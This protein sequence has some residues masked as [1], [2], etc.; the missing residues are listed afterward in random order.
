LA[1]VDTLT[2]SIPPAGL[3]FQFHRLRDFDVG[4]DALIEVVGTDTDPQASPGKLLGA[5][6]KAGPHYF[7]YDDGD[8]WT[9]YV[10]KSIVDYWLS[11][12]VPVVLI[13]VDLSTGACYWTRADV[14]TH[15]Q[16]ERGFRVR[17]PKTQRYD[18]SARDAIRMLAED[19]PPR[20][21]ELIDRSRVSAELAEINTAQQAAQTAADHVAVAERYLGLAGRL[22]QRGRYRE[23]AQR[24][25]SAVKAFRRAGELQRAAQE[26][27][28]LLRFLVDDLRNG[29]L[30]TLL[31]FDAVTPDRILPGGVEEPPR[32]WNG[33]PTDVL[34]ALDVAM[35]EAYDLGGRPGPAAD[36]AD[37][38]QRGDLAPPP[39]DPALPARLRAVAAVGDEEHAAAARAYDEAAETAREPTKILEYRVRAALHGGLVGDLRGA[40]TRLEGLQA[41]SASTSIET[42]R[43]RAYGWLLVLSARSADGA[44]AF[45]AASQ[46]HVAS[47]EALAAERAIANAFWA[48]QHS[49]QRVHELFA[50]G[51]LVGE[52]RGP[53]EAEARDREVVT[54]RELLAETDRHLARA[55][56]HQAYT[57]ARRALRLAYEDVDAAGVEQVRSRL[58][59]IWR[60]AS[61]F[62]PDP[63]TL[64]EALRLTVRTRAHL[65]DDAADLQLPPFYERLRQRADSALRER[66]VGA[67][68]GDLVGT[69]EHEGALRV[70][71][72]LSDLV[73]DE[74]L[75][76]AAVPL[77]VAGLD[78]GWGTKGSEAALRLTSEIG[79][80]LSSAGAA[81][82]RE[83]L[84]ALIPSTPPTRLDVVYLALAN[85]LGK[86]DV[87][88]DGGAALAA[89]FQAAIE[90]PQAG[91]YLPALYAAMGV[92]A[93]RATSDVRAVLVNTLRE[94]GRKSRDAALD[95]L[96]R[97]EIDFQ[98]E[99]AE[100]YLARM[101]DGL[102]NRLAEVGTNRRSG[103]WPPLLHLVRWAAPRVRAEA[104]DECLVAA[105]D[106]VDEDEHLAGERARYCP[107]VAFL[108]AESPALRHRAIESL[109]KFARGEHGEPAAFSGLGGHPLG[110]GRPAGYPPP[111]LR[112]SALYWAAHLYAAGDET[113]RRLILDRALG[114]LRDAQPEVREGALHAIALIFRVPDEAEATLSS[115]EA[116]DVPEQVLTAVRA[117]TTDAS[118]DVQLRAARLLARLVSTRSAG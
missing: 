85:V 105:L 117:A 33:V 4:V 65:S 32:G 57:A 89:E 83:R 81:V 44:A 73:P 67:I 13:L 46:L 17:V 74:H 94:E 16:T 115:H 79:H 110:F 3:G 53:A 111:N 54:V 8:S 1:I 71:A 102:R 86:A 6:V 50:D 29:D 76:T 96:V 2:C 84:L 90:R 34:L 30:A 24:H 7:R 56:L 66:I 31:A 20:L 118:A 45:R 91:Y 15:A 98:P 95:R 113:E 43:L 93:R 114:L 14:R 19:A 27:T 64:M 23:A 75:E 28:I 11:Y 88:E 12:S 36:L 51:A 72:D 37:R 80:R 63:A 42:L 107:V 59:D 41:S 68:T 100:S 106:F 9:I 99:L 87:P 112:R 21:A 92:L 97:E 47:N 22:R 116:G 58:A 55:A 49:P 39:A 18:V 35:A 109:L 104:R 62:S 103:V 25:E 70:F 82:V 52:L 26:L 61:E 69:T 10:R 48:G 5:Q 60:R 40:I 38:L 108:A 78:A 101:R 77:I